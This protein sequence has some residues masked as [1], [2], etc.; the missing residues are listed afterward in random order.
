MALGVSAEILP[1][2]RSKITLIFDA[3]IADNIA[4]Y[5]IYRAK[6]DSNKYRLV[7]GKHPSGKA[8]LRKH[9][10]KGFRGIFKGSAQGHKFFIVAVDKNGQSSDRSEIVKVE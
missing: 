7:S 10:P 1:S 9:S 2:G 8:I 6:S 4:G 3:P 5:K